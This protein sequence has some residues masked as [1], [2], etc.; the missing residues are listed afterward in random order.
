MHAKRVRVG[1]AENG[2]IGAC[3]LREIL[4]R[5]NRQNALE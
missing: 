5:L 2:D 1:E 3:M 4:V